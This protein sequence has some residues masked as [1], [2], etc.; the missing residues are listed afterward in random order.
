MSTIKVVLLTEYD[1][2]TSDTIKTFNINNELLNVIETI[3]NE[4]KYSFDS[5][6]LNRLD[7]Q[8]NE[9][10]NKFTNAD[11][12]IMVWIEINNKNTV[13]L[14]LFFVYLGRNKSR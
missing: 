6:D 13:H 3:A 1:R 10:L 14:T 11:L 8:E 4:F 5:V 9:S 2:E 7:F 12:V